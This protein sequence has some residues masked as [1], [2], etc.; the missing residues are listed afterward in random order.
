MDCNNAKKLMPEAAKHPGNIH[1]KFRR[2]RAAYV[3]KPFLYFR[4]KYVIFP[5]SSAHPRF[6]GAL[7]PLPPSRSLAVLK[8]RIIK[9]KPNPKSAKTYS[10]SDL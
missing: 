2:E 9:S 4:T 7:L 10:I 3:M 6:E 8:R 5:R 1:G